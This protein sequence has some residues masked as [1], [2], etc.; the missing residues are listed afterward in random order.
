MLLYLRRFIYLLLI[1]IPSLCGAGVE[2]YY[3]LY[4]FNNQSA[5]FND[6]DQESE[7]DNQIADPLEP[8]NQI[9]FSFNYA[10]DLAV[11]EPVSYTYKSLTPNFAQYSVRN[12]FT[13]LGN[14]VTAI[15]QVA[16]GNLEDA[17]ETI[18]RFITNFVL[19]FG[20]LFDIAS[21]FQVKQNY[22]DFGRTL[23][24]Y[25]VP[26]GPYIVL[27]I[28]GPTNFRDLIGKIV[29]FEIDPISRNFTNDTNMYLG[30]SKV[31]YIR[32]DNY[33]YINNIKY[34]SLDPYAVMKTVYCQNRDNG[35]RKL[36]KKHD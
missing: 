14:P 27:P 28:I 24:T 30:M 26:G 35:I 4:Y 15:N 17:S 25:N 21:E 29:D 33:D 7:D 3:D 18:G 5:N 32:A 1:Y 10:L 11:I 22:E 19:G 8:I 12:F 13:N 31:I 20:G 2:G 36:G 9:I 23:A 6:I 16:Q 34:K